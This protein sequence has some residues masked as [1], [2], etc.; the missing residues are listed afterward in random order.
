MENACSWSLPVRSAKAKN[1]WCHTSILPYIFMAWCL[2]KNRHKFTLTYNLYVLWHVV[3]ELW[4]GKKVNNVHLS[5]SMPWRHI[6][7]PEVQ[8]QSFLNSA[9]DGEWPNSRTGRPTPGKEP[10]YPLNR[11]KGGLHGRS[12][13]LWKTGILL[14]LPRIL[15]RPVLS[16]I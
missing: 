15:P 4:Y 1:T 9:L 16:V 6:R 7:G 2:I 8:F 10:S 3:I 14:T 5:L 11:R 13:R 12:R